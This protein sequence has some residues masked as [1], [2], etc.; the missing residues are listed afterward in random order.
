MTYD[1]ITPVAQGALLRSKISAAERTIRARMDPQEFADL[2]RA[3]R[4]AQST[5]QTADQVVE[6]ALVALGAHH[7]GLTLIR[8]RDRLETIA[9]SGDEVVRA[10]ELQYRLRE[11]PCYGSW[12]GS[13]A[14]QDLHVEARWPQWA[15]AATELGIAA[16]LVAELSDT[17]G[18]RL[19]AL[20]LYWK[21]PVTLTSDD[22]AYVSIFATHAAIALVASLQATHLNTAL[23]TRKVIGQAQ[24]ILMERHNLSTEQAFEVLRRYSQQH[25]MKLREVAHQLVETRKLPTRGRISERLAAPEAGEPPAVVDTGHTAR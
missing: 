25:N 4:A 19:G 11:G 13:L 6:H 2:A 7:G 15:P 9:P 18:H 10:D 17:D 16:L 22:L 14:S 20:N 12:R 5:E 24:G 23:D 1:E 8:A 21:E 3:L